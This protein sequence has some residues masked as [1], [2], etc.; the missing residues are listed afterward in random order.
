[1]S[2][3][4]LHFSIVLIVHTEGNFRKKSAY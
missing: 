1:M 2:C 3:K 4:N